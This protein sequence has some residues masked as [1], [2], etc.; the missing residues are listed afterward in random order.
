MKATIWL[1][2]AA[3]LVIGLVGQRATSNEGFLGWFKSQVQKVMKDGI[4]ELIVKQSWPLMKVTSGAYTDEIDAWIM[5]PNPS[6]RPLSG[7]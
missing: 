1:R 6:G 2:N 5:R 4:A 7:P 3:K